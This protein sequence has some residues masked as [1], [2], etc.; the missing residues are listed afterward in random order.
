MSRGSFALQA[1]EMVVWQGKPFYRKW[2]LPLAILVSAF[3]TALYYLA[4]QPVPPS[5]EAGQ[6]LALIL[7][8]LI[9]SWIRIDTKYAAVTYYVTDRR[10][11]RSQRFP[12]FGNAREIPL[13]SLVGIGAKRRFG[14]GY[15]VFQSRDTST[16]TFGNLHENPEE[17]K[18]ATER[19]ML[20][21]RPSLHQE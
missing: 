1:G 8:L 6:G 7:G 14:R 17:L 11:V 3:L 16:L 18:K 4:P 20:A 9:L 12:I 2:G 15:V 21:R 5:T 19:T 10:V 13:Q